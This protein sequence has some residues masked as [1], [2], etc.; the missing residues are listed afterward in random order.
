MEPKN[1][2]IQK[3]HQLP[4][5]HSWEHRRQV[6][7]FP[8]F[9]EVN[10]SLKNI[11][12]SSPKK[13]I[14]IK[15]KRSNEFPVSAGWQDLTVL[16]NFLSLVE[17]GQALLFRGDIHQIANF[18]CLFSPHFARNKDNWHFLAPGFKRLS[19]TVKKKPRVDGVV[20]ADTHLC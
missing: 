4:N 15:L 20:Q 5:L 12:A 18:L 16:T 6:A 19:F 9:S 10:N 3:E 2:P 8:H 17:S 14:S 1:H 13:N 7:S 11:F